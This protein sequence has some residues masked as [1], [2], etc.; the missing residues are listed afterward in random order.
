M[1]DSFERGS[2]FFYQLLSV[3]MQMSATERTF[4]IF[5]I[6]KKTSKNILI[7]FPLSPIIQ[8]VGSVVESNLVVSFFER[9]KVMVSGTFTIHTHLGVQKYANNSADKYRITQMLDRKNVPA[10][11]FFGRIGHPLPRGLSELN[12]VTVLEF[13]PTESGHGFSWN[14]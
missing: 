12:N 4:I 1:L 7:S 10:G 13:T 14:P 5:A 2:P 9:E 8:S 6:L 11:E 3:A